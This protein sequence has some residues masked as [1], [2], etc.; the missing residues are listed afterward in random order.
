MEGGRDLRCETKKGLPQGK[1]RGS[2]S[3]KPRE[4]GPGS[5]VEHKCWAGWVWM[6]WLGVRAFKAGPRLAAS[7]TDGVAWPICPLSGLS[8]LL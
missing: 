5:P 3:L 8:V 2:T 7:V 1:G 4:G 6:V